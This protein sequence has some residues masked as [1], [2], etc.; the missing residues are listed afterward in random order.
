MGDTRGASS[1]AVVRVTVLEDKV[2]PTAVDDTFETVRNV[3]LKYLNV[4]AN[5]LNPEADVITLVSVGQ[6][7]RP[8]PCPRLLPRTTR[9]TTCRRTTLSAPTTLTTPSPTLVTTR[10]PPP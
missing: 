5:D 8:A 10:R 3:E 1:T 2:G 9:S 6:T 4:M 7:K